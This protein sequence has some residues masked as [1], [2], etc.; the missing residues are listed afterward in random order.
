M[1]KFKRLCIGTVAEP[2]ETINSIVIQVTL[3]ELLPFEDGDKISSEEQ[4]TSYGLDRIGNAYSSTI[5]VDKA[6]DAT[7]LREGNRVTAPDVIRGEKVQIYRNDTDDKLY[8]S[9]LGVGSAFQRRK[10]ETIVHAIG[11][12]DSPGD[13]TEHTS[14][15]CYT[16]TTSGHKK[17]I[18]LDMPEVPGSKGHIRVT[19]DHANGE[20]LIE[21]KDV[22]TIKAT[23][24]YQASIQINGGASLEMDNGDVSIKFDK[25]TLEGSEADFKIGK[26]NWKGDLE[27]KGNINNSGTIISNNVSVDKH[28]HPETGSTTQKPVPGT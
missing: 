17:I 26:S 18:V 2:K 6:V 5:T 25:I 4:Y 23:S 22:V 3:D 24:E 21:I 19:L 14:D 12:D 27:H 28:E 9:E 8:W 13:K 11:A 20:A 1:S 10:Q 7:W 16:L 15:N